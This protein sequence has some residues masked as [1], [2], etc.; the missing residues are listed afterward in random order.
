LRNTIGKKINFANVVG[1]GNCAI[2]FTINSSG[3]L[4][5]RKFSQQS[6]N[7]TLNDAVYSAMRATPSFNPPPEGY[8]N[9]TLTFYV[10]IY[11]GNY[12]IS[13]R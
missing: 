10:K 11:D 3:K 5:N 9:E 12:E 6:S 13:L 1:D 4:T 7:I 2:T 8:K